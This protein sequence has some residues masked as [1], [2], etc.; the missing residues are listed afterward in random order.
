[1]LLHL[2]LC[3]TAKHENSLPKNCS[4]STRDNSSSNSFF[5]KKK[6]VKNQKE[7]KRGREQQNKNWLKTT[8]SQSKKHSL[9]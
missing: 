4:S 3:E 7:K 8:A 5:Q 9:K 6:R 1:M 2:S